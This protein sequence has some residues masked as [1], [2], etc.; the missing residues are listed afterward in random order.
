M[1]RWTRREAAEEGKA[2]QRMREVRS[3]AMYS[4]TSVSWLPW[5]NESSKHTTFKPLMRK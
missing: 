1:M 5:R 3:E 2:D 4:Q